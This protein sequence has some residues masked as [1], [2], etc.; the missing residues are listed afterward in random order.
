VHYLVWLVLIPQDDVAAQG[1]ATFRMSA[2]SLL[3]D[4]GRFGLAAIALGTLLVAVGALFEARATR[5]LYL[6][7]AMF[8]VYLEL[9]LAGWFWVRG[10]HLGGPRAA[11]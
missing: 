5:E 10:G 2:R 7:L 8:H 4:L 6:S 1:T 11:A 3:R 9:A